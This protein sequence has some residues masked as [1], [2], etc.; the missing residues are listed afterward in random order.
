MSNFRRVNM[1]AVPVA[2]VLIALM[3]PRSLEVLN[4]NVAKGV[5]FIVGSAFIG[6]LFGC[7]IGLLVNLIVRKNKIVVSD[8]TELDFDKL[9]KAILL[10]PIGVFLLLFVWNVHV[11]LKLTH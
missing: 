8:K 9:D 10:I 11:F 6:Y 4:E 1:I 5:G 7:P 2:V 3:F